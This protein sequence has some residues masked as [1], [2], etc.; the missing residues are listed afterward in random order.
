M[1][2][3]PFFVLVMFSVSASAQTGFYRS[4]VGKMGIGMGYQRYRPP[5]RTEAPFRFNAQTI[6]GNLDYMFNNDL[7]IS[8]L[9]GISFFEANTQ[10]PYEIAPSPSIDIR[11]LNVN[12]MN[13]SGLKFFILGG[14]RTQ[15][16]NIVRSWNLPLHSVNMNIRGGVGL[17]HILETDYAWNLKPFFGMFYTQAWNN[18]ST[19]RKV[20]MNTAHNFFTGEAG[21]EVELSPTMS[22][23]GSVEFSFE[24]SELLYR[25]GLNF[26]QAPT[27]KIQNDVT[28]QIRRTDTSPSPLATRLAGIDF[29]P[30]PGVT[31][32][33]YKFRVEPLYPVIAKN[34]KIEG[35]VV[36]EATI[37]EQ[38]I[39]L[40]I[41]ALTNLGFGLEEAAIEALKRT[42][43][44]PAMKDGEMISK[45]VTLRYRFTLRN[46]N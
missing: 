12:D 10:I 8:L 33:E 9:P 31:A 23:I 46:T 37:N 21:L 11:L 1:L 20:H 25:F 7:R 4:P 32:P 40:D 15:Y 34:V 43:F 29:E 38:G 27:L 18:V 44:Y 42:T 19:T 24:S 13:M 5:K 3:I 16:T 36:L 2:V 6:L 35:E 26:H 22:A 14:F 39:P 41:V 30:E 28:P 17:L 45:Q